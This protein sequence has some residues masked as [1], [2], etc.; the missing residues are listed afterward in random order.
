MRRSAQDVIRNLQ[1]RIARLERVASLELQSSDE[2]EMKDLARQIEM[3][4]GI[5]GDLEGASHDYFELGAGQLASR[6]AP[7]M[8]TEVGQKEMKDLKNFDKTFKT[9]SKM[10]ASQRKSL[11]ALERKIK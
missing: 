7:H 10:L 5:I 2:K 4:R 1:Q 3:A 8:E 6:I 9:L 11:D